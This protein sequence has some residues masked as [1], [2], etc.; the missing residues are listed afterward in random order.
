M[1]FNCSSSTF[2]P[3][4][5]LA[6]LKNQI[7]RICGAPSASRGFPLTRQRAGGALL[8]EEV[9][10]QRR[11]VHIMYTRLS[12]YCFWLQVFFHAILFYC[13][14]NSIIQLL[15]Q[16]SQ[17]RHVSPK[18]GFPSFALVQDSASHPP[19]VPE[20]GRKENIGII[21]SRKAAE[22]CP[23]TPDRLPQVLLPRQKGARGGCPRGPRHSEL[24]SRV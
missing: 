22:L 1:H 2:V 15:V 7:P 9:F 12:F 19:Q 16:K 24:A 21:F 5:H 13:Y 17:V 3:N 23:S 6:V 18:K 20:R 8:A 14:T 11:T 10:W 4:R